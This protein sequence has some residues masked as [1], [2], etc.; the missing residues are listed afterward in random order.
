MHNLGVSTAA[1]GLREG[2][3]SSDTGQ[4]CGGTIPLCLST[5]EPVP[6]QRARGI[7]GA[8]WTQ[9]KEQV[10]R[11]VKQGAKWALSS[12]GCKCALTF[13]VFQN[14]SVAKCWYYKRPCDTESAVYTISSI[15]KSKAKIK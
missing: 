10:G 5:P 12:S 13:F 7:W 6:E 11:L 2:K 15:S 1:L 14:W 4:A 3:A 8:L 9:G